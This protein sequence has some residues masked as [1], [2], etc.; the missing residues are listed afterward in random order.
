VVDDRLATV[1]GTSISNNS[2]GTLTFQDDQDH[3]VEKVQLIED[4]GTSLAGATGT[5]SIGGDS[6]TDQVVPLG[7]LTDRYADLFTFMVDLPQNT[8]FELA[9]DNGSGGSIT[10]DLVLYYSDHMGSG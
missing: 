7:V 1:E 2:T 9:I 8:E 5:I 4:S 6:I 3:T 10:V